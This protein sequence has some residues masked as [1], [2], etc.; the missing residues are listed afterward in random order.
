MAEYRHYRDRNTGELQDYPVALAAVFRNL[1]EVG[2]DAKPLAY[3]P[4][5]HSVVEEYLA[6]ASEPDDDDASDEEEDEA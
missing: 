5:P 3:V 4:I 2:P 6:S 1:E